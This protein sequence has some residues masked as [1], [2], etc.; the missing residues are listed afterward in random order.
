MKHFFI[1]LFISTL[2]SCIVESETTYSYLIKNNSSSSIE[3]L[4]LENLTI[5]P[6]EQITI[7]EDYQKGKST[8]PTLFYLSKLDT[9][10][11]SNSLGELL[12]KDIYTVQNWVF[13]FEEKR[14]T[15][16]QKYILSIQDNDF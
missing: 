7:W 13:D 16:W 8:N 2:S 1:I 10:E 3:I 12:Q 9:I 11:I 5:M 14:H 15:V 6:N 4:A